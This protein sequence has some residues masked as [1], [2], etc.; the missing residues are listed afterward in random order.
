MTDS[1]AVGLDAENSQT[2]MRF[3]RLGLPSSLLRFMVTG[4]LAVS[5]DGGTYFVL[6]HLGSPVSVAKAA[7]FIAGALFAYFANR[8]WAFTDAVNSK[9]SFMPFVLLYSTSIVLNV[10][11]NR[12]GLWAQADLAVS[13]FVA[14]ACSAALNYLGMRFFVFR[15]AES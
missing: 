1:Y 13:W 6:L 7:G 14:T 15:K 4:V 8:F 11:V 9:K 10:S 2:G 12:A 5:I 3:A